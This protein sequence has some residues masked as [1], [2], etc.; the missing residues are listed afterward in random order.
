MG[1]GPRTKFRFVSIETIQLIKGA[2]ALKYA[3]DAV[4]GIIKT[5]FSRSLLMDSCMDL[6]VL[7]TQIMEGVTM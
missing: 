2:G 7:V 6:E 3:G 1:S 4:G 5:N